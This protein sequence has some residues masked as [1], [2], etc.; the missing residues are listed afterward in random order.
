[1]DHI[2]LEGI[3][4]IYQLCGLKFHLPKF[5]RISCSSWSPDIQIWLRSRLTSV[6]GY[7]NVDKFDCC[8]QDMLLLYNIAW[9]IHSRAI[10]G[11]AGEGGG[12]LK[13]N[14]N[15]KLQY[16]SIFYSL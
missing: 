11:G 3:T 8:E 12:F 4:G 2:H 13:V 15:S 7:D 16:C 5:S 1:M 6:S 10:T 9:I 14:S